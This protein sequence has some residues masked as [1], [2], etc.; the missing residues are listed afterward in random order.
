MEK[1]Y[2]E[3]WVFSALNL[4]TI[5]HGFSEKMKIENFDDEIILNCKSLVF[6]FESWPN[7]TFYAFTNGHLSQCHLLSHIKKKSYLYTT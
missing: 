1:F 3:F 5:L 4:K 2:G 7:W 6:N